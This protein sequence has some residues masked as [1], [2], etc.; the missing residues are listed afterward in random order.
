MRTPL[1]VSHGGTR[2][3]GKGGDA[4]REGEK[5]GK[6]A[7]AGAGLRG[8]GAAETAEALSEVGQ[9]GTLAGAGTTQGDTEGN[10]DSAVARGEREAGSGGA[11][12]SF[13]ALPV[14]ENAGNVDGLS[15]D[16]G[17]GGGLRGA[18]TGGGA[19]IGSGFSQGAARTVKVMPHT[20]S[21]QYGGA[22]GV[23]MAS[24]RG[25]ATRL[26]GTAFA[27]AR[28]SGWGA[29]NPFAVVTHYNGGVPS[30]ALE[31]PASSNVTAGVTV[32]LP[33]RLPGPLRGWR[34]GVFATA[35]EGV[36]SET[37]VS[38]PLYGWVL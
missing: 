27:Q 17:F 3:A 36:R 38:T 7:A 12:L 28:Q 13:H 15:G 33:V 16:Q 9:D 1:D 5:Q 14:T 26:H 23:V 11:A 32:G 4:D 8:L 22:G 35:E 24:S 25:A 18:G 19:R 21:A 34:S 31:R 29:V 20:F 10:D 30:S 37:L 2:L 6:V